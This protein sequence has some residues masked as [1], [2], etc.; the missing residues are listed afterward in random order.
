MPH[1]R[2]AVRWEKLTALVVCSFQR[3]NRSY[4]RIE[5]AM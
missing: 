4:G 3:S 1:V 5:L 2:R